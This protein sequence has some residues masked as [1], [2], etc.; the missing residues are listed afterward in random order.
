MDYIFIEMRTCC[1][2]RV[3]YLQ[4][5]EQASCIAVVDLCASSSGTIEFHKA[6]AIVYSRNLYT[7][8]VLSLALMGARLVDK[9][10]N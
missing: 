7:L 3:L 4:V 10:R 6:I 1:I 8:L 2:T 5:V 9:F